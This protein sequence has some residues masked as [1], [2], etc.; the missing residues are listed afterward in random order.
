MKLLNEA[1]SR[2]QSDH[3]VSSGFY[4]E[5]LTNEQNPN[6]ELY[7]LH[8]LLANLRSALERYIENMIEE[9]LKTNCNIKY[10]K[11]LNKTDDVHI[12]TSALLIA[13]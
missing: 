6:C 7:Q 1:S 13:Q 8:L 4:T 3:S 11:L 2:L 9:K 10:Q 12:T 5:K